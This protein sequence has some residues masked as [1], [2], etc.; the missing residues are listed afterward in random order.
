MKHRI[1]QVDKSGYVEVQR[2]RWWWPFWTTPITVNT[3]YN[4]FESTEKA[5]RQ[6]ELEHKEPFAKKVTWSS[7]EEAA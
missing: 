5:L 7:D 2:W 3:R 1:V 6:I 4:H